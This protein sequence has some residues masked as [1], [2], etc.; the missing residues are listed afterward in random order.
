M[1]NRIIKDVSFYIVIAAAITF[2]SE[3]FE[4]Q[5]LYTYLKEHLI[6]L[7]I[8][9]MAINTAT[10]GLI[11]SK[12]QDIQMSHPQREFPDTIKEMK[13]SLKEQI[14]LVVLSILVLI[15]NDSPN[16]E[17]A[18][19]GIVFNIILTTILTYAIAILWDT[20]NAVFVSLEVSKK[21]E[22]KKD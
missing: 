22:K 11:A 4:T 20:G 19:K 16:T 3:L 13:L 12:I 18:Y 1:W 14:A 9:L 21:Q 7:L 5:F 17:F 15:V 8:T 10:L 6:G 2:F